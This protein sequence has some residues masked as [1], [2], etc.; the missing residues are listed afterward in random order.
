[1]PKRRLFLEKGQRLGHWTVLEEAHKDKWRRVFYLAQCKCGI[2]KSVAAYELSR[3]KTA[4]CHACSMKTF[5]EQRALL[6]IQLKGDVEKEKEAQY[7]VGNWEKR[8]H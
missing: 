1:M 8:T 2:I 3:G 4:S 5:K 7:F 6:K